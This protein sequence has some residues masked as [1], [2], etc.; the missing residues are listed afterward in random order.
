MREVKGRG[1]EVVGVAKS[2]S[3]E[4]VRGYA[5]I[6][7]AGV[8]LKGE[9]DVRLALPKEAIRLLASR[10]L[11]QGIT[12]SEQVTQALEDYFKKPRGAFTPAKKEL[13]VLN[14]V[15]DDEQRTRQGREKKLSE[16]IEGLK[17]RLKLQEQSVRAL[18]SVSEE[19]DVLRRERD[20]LLDRVEELEARVERDEKAKVLSVAAQR[21]VERLQRSIERVV[22]RE[23]ER[24]KR[25]GATAVLGRARVVACVECGFSFDRM[26]GREGRPGRPATKCRE[27]GG[28]AGARLQSASVVAAPRD[29]L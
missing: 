15:A 28:S 12:V 17:L 22:A 16:E 27:C 10:K 7:E 25:V 23:Q 24:A 20:A 6:R 1:V 29:D 9:K 26:E 11:F 19:R 3:D 8:E 18:R 4:P 5:G 13:N 21:R 14:H 2:A